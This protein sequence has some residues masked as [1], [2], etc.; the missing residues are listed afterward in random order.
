MLESGVDPH[1]Y[2]VSAA[3]LRQ[4]I[5]DGPG[6]DALKRRLLNYLARKVVKGGT[7]ANCL[8]LGMALAEFAEKTDDEDIIPIN[9][10]LR[11]LNNL[12]YVIANGRPVS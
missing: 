5:R 12:P 11:D 3:K 8:L 9:D 6:S 4:V 1:A 2:A 7:T 10:R